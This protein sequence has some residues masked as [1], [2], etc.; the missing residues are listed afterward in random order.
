MPALPVRATK[1][2]S[3]GGASTEKKTTAA[4]GKNRFAQFVESID[5][6]LELGGKA[7]PREKLNT[8]IANV[9]VWSVV[10]NRK[11]L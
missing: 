3:R 9:W 10:Q 2:A 8:P 4:N 7:A 1:F 11:M 6:L 5:C